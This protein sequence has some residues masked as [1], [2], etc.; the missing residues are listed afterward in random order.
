MTLT[1]AHISFHNLL[2]HPCSL[3]LFL[4]VLW[5]TSMPT[6]CLPESVSPGPPHFWGGSLVEIWASWYICHARQYFL[7]PVLWALLHDSNRWFPTLTWFANLKEEKK[8]ESS[9]AVIS[10]FILTE[11]ETRRKREVQGTRVNCSEKWQNINP[12][13]FLCKRNGGWGILTYDSVSL[14][15][16][17][18]CSFFYQSQHTYEYEEDLSF[19]F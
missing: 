19:F 2:Y 18:H 5:N 6:K 11:G 4:H 8:N 7:C 16:I 3:Q 9:I 13:I 14:Y 17:A 10:F 12:H 15:F 1:Q